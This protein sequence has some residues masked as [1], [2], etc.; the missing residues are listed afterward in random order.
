[1]SATYAYV[2]KLVMLTRL[3]FELGLPLP[4][5]LRAAEADLWPGDCMT[6][7]CHAISASEDRVVNSASN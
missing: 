7:Q 5:A 1:M 2:E 3:Y 6:L 4:D